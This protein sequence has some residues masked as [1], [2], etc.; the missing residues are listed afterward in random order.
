MPVKGTG[1]IYLLRDKFQIYTAL[2]PN[3]LEFHFVPDIVRDLDVVN[4]ELFENII[5]IFIESNKILPCSFIIAL[6][7]N[8]CFIKDF[9]Q[10]DR[11]PVLAVATKESQVQKQTQEK[12]ED[13]SKNELKKQKEEFLDHIPFEIVA[14]KEFQLQNG[15]R[16]I[17]T[18]QE[19]IDAIKTTFEKNGFSIDFVIPGG[20]YGS[21]ISS[22]PVLTPAAANLI[23]QLTPTLKQYNLLV[24][25]T[26]EPEKNE[27]EIDET[28]TQEVQK[29]KTDKKRIIIMSGVFGILII[30]LIVVYM[31]SNTNSASTTTATQPVSSVQ[32]IT[33]PPLSQ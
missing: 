20:L 6:A 23:L 4:K 25:S 16:I 13:E 30:V 8:V 21:N 2:Q 31:S 17:A 22:Q 11:R 33:N 15:E 27:S 10:P 5:K 3:V 28:E 14:S 12:E 1:V 24:Q 18:N 9:A 26:H 32:T 19:L 7:D 29:P